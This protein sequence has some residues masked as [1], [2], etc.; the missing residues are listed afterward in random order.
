MHKTTGI[1]FKGK[2]NRQH[3]N[4]IVPADLKVVRLLQPSVKTCKV[5][6]AFRRIVIC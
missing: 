6:M 4:R 5:I 3:L 2:A 1:V